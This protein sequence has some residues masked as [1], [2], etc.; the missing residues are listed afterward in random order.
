MTDIGL[1]GWVK[2]YFENLKSDAT[3][4]LWVTE[5]NV[6][7]EFHVEWLDAESRGTFWLDN[8]RTVDVYKRQPMNNPMWLRTPIRYGIRCR[9]RLTGWKVRGNA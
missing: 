4:C 7:E 8:N 6:Q 9:Q 3:L 1:E 5:G 2:V